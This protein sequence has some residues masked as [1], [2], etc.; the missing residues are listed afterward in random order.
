MCGQQKYVLSHKIRRILLTAAVNLAAM[1][2]VS[3]SG[4]LGGEAKVTLD[5]SPEKFYH[6]QL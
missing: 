3:G 6:C 1:M 4:I 2:K 5:C